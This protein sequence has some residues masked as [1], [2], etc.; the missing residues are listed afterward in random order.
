MGLCF[1]QAVIEVG[2]EL[3]ALLGG[4]DSAGAPI[5]RIR[6]ALDKTRCFEVVE[7]VGHDR[8]VD[9]EVLS[10]S[11]LATDCAMRSSGEYLVTPRTPG[12]IGHRV[13]SRFD[14]GT[15]DRA[16]APPEVVG[17]GVVT[18]GD[19]PGFFW[20]P[21]TLSTA[22]SIRAR[23]EKSCSVRC[24]VDVMICFIYQLTSQG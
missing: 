7:Q 9:A 15:K 18:S 2:E 5:G 13:V 19:D 21:G 24:S 4:D 23:A 1:P 6:T 17:Q 22:Q 11:E 16:Q 14:V 12:Q 3:D 8:A 10:Q 20:G